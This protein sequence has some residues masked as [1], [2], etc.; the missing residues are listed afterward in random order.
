M[1]G[2]TFV[3][4]YAKRSINNARKT[5]VYRW[6]DLVARQ[7][8]LRR[9]TIAKWNI[10]QWDL[11]KKEKA[12]FFIVMKNWEKDFTKVVSQLFSQPVIPYVDGAQDKTVFPKYKINFI[13]NIVSNIMGRLPEQKQPTLH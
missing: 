4:L 10:L 7:L 13:S 5:I 6:E 12:K 8:L 11:L 3:L 2:Q 9:M 1:D